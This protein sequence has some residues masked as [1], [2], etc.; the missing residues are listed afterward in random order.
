MSGG[1][2]L[3]GNLELSRRP[4]ETQNNEL[5]LHVD[6]G[7]VCALRH[8]QCSD[9]QDRHIFH[10]ASESNG[11]DRKM[12]HILFTSDWLD[13]CRKCDSWAKL[14]LEPQDE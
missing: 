12:H 5:P 2:A 8:R 10:S 11:E 1:A 14:A 7:P 6:Y 3:Y 13:M 9:R 4:A